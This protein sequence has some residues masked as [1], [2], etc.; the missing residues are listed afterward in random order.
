MRS[1]LRLLPASVQ[2]KLM[3][4]WLGDNALSRYLEKPL[5]A[6]NK[7]I[8]QVEFLVLDFETTG[9]DAK[10]DSILSMGYTIIRNRRVVLGESVYR[11]IQQDALL[12]SD[13]VSI[14]K[15]TDSDAEQGIALKQAIDKLLSDLS[16]KILVAH[17]AEIEQ[18]FLNAA[19][20]QL[21][22]FG[23][24]VAI[25]DTLLL[26]KKKL[27]RQHATIKSNQL[28]LFNLR[29]AYGLPRYNAHNA[30]EDAVSTAELLLMQVSNICGQ[31]SCHLKDL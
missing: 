23:L 12:N 19:C 26:E 6:R 11:L 4:H 15:I 14:H 1:L 31:K 10:K 30:L 29:K 18:S 21:Y 17:H 28:R 24:P 13:N 22:G 2:R 8:S 16:G 20:Q 5:P 9:L 3:L 27:E 7:D 25:I